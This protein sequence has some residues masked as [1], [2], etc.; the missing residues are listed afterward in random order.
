MAT[1]PKPPKASGASF[2]NR[3]LKTIILAVVIL[4]IA[5]AAS[6]GAT[7]YLLAERGNPTLTNGKP[8]A[9]YETLVPAFVVTINHQGRA[10]YMQVS[11]TMMGR[12]PEQMLALKNH[13][14]MLRNRLVMLLSEYSFDQL[15]TAEGKALLIEQASKTVQQIAQEQVGAPVVERL[16]FTNIVLQ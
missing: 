12:D 2:F 9:L 6:A 15:A 3:K 13:M 5:V 14:P 8:Q 10:R 4:L 11:M 16:L 7:W 1:K